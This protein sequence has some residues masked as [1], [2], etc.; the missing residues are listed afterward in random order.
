MISFLKKYKITIFLGLVIVILCFMNTQSLPSVK[1]TDFDKLAHFLMFGAL[2]GTLFFE[3]SGYFKNKI[4]NAKLFLLTF[5]FPTL[6]SGL[7]ELIQEYF[8]SNRTGDW[9]DFLF[10]GIGAFTAFIICLLINK[11]I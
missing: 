1:M 11:R 8:T 4:S 6:F 7:I 9:F 2:G 3:R 10:D 5:L